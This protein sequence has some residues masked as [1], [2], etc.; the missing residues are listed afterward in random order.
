[1][2]STH[3]HQLQQAHIQTF[4]H[5][6]LHS[7]SLSHT[8]IRLPDEQII[9]SLASAHSRQW[10]IC[11]HP[12]RYLCSWLPR[13]LVENHFLSTI[14]AWL[15][16]H[17]PTKRISRQTL[18]NDHWWWRGILMNIWL[19]KDSKFCSIH[20][21]W[22]VK[23]TKIQ[24]S[25]RIFFNTSPVDLCLC[26][27]SEHVESDPRKSNVNHGPY[28]QHSHSFFFFSAGEVTGSLG[29]YFTTSPSMSHHT[30]LY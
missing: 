27:P 20:N 25:G 12:S 9:M 17:L 24:T 22:N 21:I 2:T 13:R 8:H 4:T 3:H 6:H 11:Q 15:S 14:I 26:A 5:T 16:H 7:H 18:S 1:M 19:H 28:R 10:L 29:L 30:F 23:K